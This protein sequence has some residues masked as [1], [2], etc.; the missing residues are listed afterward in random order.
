M[1]RSLSAQPSCPMI[2]ALSSDREAIDDRVIRAEASKDGSWVHMRLIAVRC[3]LH[4]TRK[5]QGHV[6]PCDASFLNIEATSER[7][8]K[9]SLPCPF[10]DD[11]RSDSARH[12]SAYSL[13][14]APR[15]VMLP[16]IFTSSLTN[17]WSRIN[18]RVHCKTRCR[19]AAWT[20]SASVGGNLY[21][22][23]NSRF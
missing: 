11:S 22:R 10:T 13:Y 1:R 20:Q 23:D 12:K 21:A 4:S 18:R 7:I 19:E 15:V 14:F 6:A 16:S 5:C 9:R 17:R 2:A 3:A 8:S